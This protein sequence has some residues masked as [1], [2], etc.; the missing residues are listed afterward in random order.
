MLEIRRTDK[1]GVVQLLDW[2]RAEGWNPGIDDAAPF[3]V[4][5][6][7]GFLLGFLNGEA[8]SGISV[9]SSGSGF[10]FLGLYIV[11]P[12]HRG[13]GFGVA[14][15]SAG[16]AK[17]EGRTIG[18]DGVVAQQANYA[19]SGF[20]FA[21][22]NI[23][24]CGKRQAGADV[25][26]ARPIGSDDIAKIVAFDA[27]RY[28]ARR[29]DF[30]RSWLDGSGGRCGFCVVEDG[31]LAGYGVVRPCQS[32]F[33][34]GPLFARR[35]DVAEALFARMIEAAGN[36]DVFIDVPEPNTESLLMMQRFGF[37]PVF[38]TARMYRGPRPDLPLHEIYGLTSF[39][40]G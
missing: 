8:V 5:D 3:H 16:I 4:A 28:G 2:A 1:S 34:I 7:D 14:T 35:A 6:Y 15:W 33:K 25:G 31:A 17:L 22:R 36:D 27:P 20:A 38:E 30:L 13:R 23:R 9:V 12:I 10:G 26:N 39:E 29:P 40:L 21:H 24:F 19:R 32:G 37:S 18:L 11:A